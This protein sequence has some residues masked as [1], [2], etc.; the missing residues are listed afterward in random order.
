VLTSRSG[1][2]SA[3]GTNATDDSF[4]RLTDSNTRGVD[5]NGLHGIAWISNLNNGNAPAIRSRIGFMNSNLSE[6]FNCAAIG[7]L[8]RSN[9]CIT[10]LRFKFLSG[11]ISSGRFTVY[12]LKAS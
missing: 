2:T 9:E 4:L 12:G 1:T 3:F 11:N 6:A 7:I 5:G 10:Q 8:E